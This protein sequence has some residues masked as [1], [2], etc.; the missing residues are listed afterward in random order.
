MTED[1]KTDFASPEAGEYW[2]EMKQKHGDNIDIDAIKGTGK[3]GS[4]TKGNVTKYI[5]AIEKAIIESAEEVPAADDAPV[6]DSD[7][8]EVESTPVDAPAE[9]PEEAPV[10]EPEEAPEDEVEAPAE[11][12]EGSKL[13]NLTANRLE[14]AGVLRLEANGCSIYTDKL[15]K[16]KAVQR[17]IDL[18][19]IG[20]E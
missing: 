6:S 14:I 10:E 20:V 8:D 1:K 15:K 12:A 19:M 18:G 16:D 3:E 9:A 17:A 4:I 11:K 13:V 5:E 2:A 7:E